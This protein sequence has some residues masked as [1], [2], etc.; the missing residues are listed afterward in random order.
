MSLATSPRRPGN[1]RTCRRSQAPM[2]PTVRGAWPAEASCGRFA[3]HLIQS[4]S[5][6]HLPSGGSLLSS[7]SSAFPC[8][9]ARALTG[10]P[11]VAGRLLPPP[12]SSKPPFLGGGPLLRTCCSR[13]PP[14]RRQRSG[15]PWL[16]GLGRSPAEPCRRDRPSAAR[17]PDP[18]SVA[19][20]PPPAG[21]CGEAW[22]LRPPRLWPLRRM[23]A[24]AWGLQASGGRGSERH[25]PL[26]GRVPNGWLPGGLCSLRPA[27]P[28]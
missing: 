13:S 16:P 27:F 6:F 23:R 4:A 14:P 18:G 1:A 3:R 9:L 11:R 21:S 15:L 8:F 28:A 7:S 12:E 20:G 25:P 17:R 5:P 26:P 19:T 22:A 24:P 10:L 2:P